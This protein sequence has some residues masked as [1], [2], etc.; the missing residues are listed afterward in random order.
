MLWENPGPQQPAQITWDL[1]EPLRVRW[2]H[3]SGEENKCFS[4]YLTNRV[5]FPPVT[6]LVLRYVRMGQDEVVIPPPGP[7]PRPLNCNYR[8]WATA[9]GQPET[10]FAETPN[11]CV[12]D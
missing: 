9:V 3:V 8:L 11:L 1:T 4:I 6:E 7:I 10:I 2:S 5:D 12:K